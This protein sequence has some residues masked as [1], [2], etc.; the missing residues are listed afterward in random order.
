MRITLGYPDQASERALLAGQD[1]REAIE[2]L[3]TVMTLAELLAAQQAVLAVHASE[4]CSTT[5]RP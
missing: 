2:H 1:R 5:C 4:A 3:P